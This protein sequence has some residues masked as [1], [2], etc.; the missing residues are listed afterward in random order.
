MN[1]YLEIGSVP[2]AEECA[3]VGADDYQRLSRIECEVFGDQI[4]RHYPVPEKGA[5]RSKSFQHDFGS[6]R[7]V[8]C[9][10]SDEESREWAYE[11]EC[12]PKGVLGSWDDPARALLAERLGVQVPLLPGADHLREQVKADRDRELRHAIASDFLKASE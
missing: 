12:D 7:E 9:Y 3:Q 2:A 5:I 8:C 6:Y 11:V 4:R 10:Y 1:D